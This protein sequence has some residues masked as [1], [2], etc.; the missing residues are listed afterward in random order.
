M[1]TSRPHRR[2]PQQRAGAVAAADA[3]PSCQ[4]RGVCA[5]RRRSRPDGAPRASRGT[6][7]IARV[8]TKSFVS[9]VPCRGTRPCRR[10][11]DSVS[12]PRNRS[13]AP[14]AKR[15]WRERAAHR[16][17]AVRALRGVRG[18]GAGNEGTQ[19]DRMEF[20]PSFVDV[21]GRQFAYKEVTQTI[22]GN[23]SAVCG[24]REAAGQVQAVAAEIRMNWH[25]LTRVRLRARPSAPRP[26]GAM[27]GTR[28]S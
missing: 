23:D 11:C 21:T 6:S 15:R 24:L 10:A 14:Y 7:T 17:R 16:H 25:A 27:Q 5:P 2:D 28:G 12:S 9:R 20:P 4:R 8:S 13:A 18:V 1:C 3:G 19:A 26:C 22:R